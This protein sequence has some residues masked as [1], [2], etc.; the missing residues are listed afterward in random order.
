[1]VMF[2]TRLAA[3][4]TA[5]FAATAT[6]WAQPS[7][8]EPT[9]T[10]SGPATAAADVTRAPDVLVRAKFVDYT[11][12]HPGPKVKPPDTRGRGDTRTCPGEDSDLCNDFRDG[13]FRWARGPV[14]YYVNSAG[15][16]GAAL[17]AIQAG[18]DAWEK[19][20]KSPAVGQVYGGDQSA[21]DYTYAGSWNAAGAARDDHNTV[22]FT[23]LSSSCSGCLAVTT[24]WFGRGTNSLAEADI[25]LNSAYP[26]STSG[27]ANAYDVRDIVTHEAGHTLV[28]GDLYQSRDRAL[29]MYGYGALGETLKRDLGAGDVLGV[30]NAYPSTS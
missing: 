7:Q 26:W 17:N 1:M 16:P 4:V 18:F 21:I 23:N 6:A 15:G 24:Y 14:P 27:A 3:A 12:E 25:T 28:L 5:V 10:D 8:A 11:R 2:K 13:L 20:I 22:S 30:R 9:R 19:E 29:T